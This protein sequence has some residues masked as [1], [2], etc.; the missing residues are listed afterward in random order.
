MNSNELDLEIAR[1]IEQRKTVIKNEKTDMVKKM[2]ED[3]KKYGI[4]R[5]ELSTAFKKR[6]AKVKP[7]V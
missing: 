1:L 5:I 4:T 2:K 6:K 3:I 7:T